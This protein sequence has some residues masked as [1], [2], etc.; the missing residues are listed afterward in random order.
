MNREAALK[1]VRRIVEIPSPSGEE[2][3]LASHLVAEMER[4]GLRSHVDGAGNAVGESGRGDRPLILLLGHM[5]TVPGPIPV[6]E[7]RGILY[8]RGAVDAK[9]PLA[10][11]IC[12]ASAL[13]DVP[14]RVVVVGAVEEET[15]RARGARHILDHYD[16]QAVIIGEPSGWSGVVLGYKG[17]VGLSL[18][19]ARPPSHS[20]SPGEKAVEA[21]VAFWNHLTEYLAARDEGRSLFHRPV[22]TLCELHGSLD[23][24]RIEITCRI[25]PAFDLEEL[26][27]F[28]DTERGDDPLVVE[29]ATPAVVMDRSVS[30]ARAIVGA[31]RRHGGKPVMKVKAGTSD[32]NVVAQ[33]WSCPMVA[34]GP[35]DSSLDHTPDE[36]LD[37]EEYLRAI[38]V[39]REAL[40]T[41]AG[42]LAVPEEPPSG[43]PAPPEPALTP[44]DEEMVAS[45]L[46][47]LGYVE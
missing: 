31:I 17:R 27:R 20:S 23:Q 39:L 33:R 38:D 19:V 5:D 16:P 13:R 37:L 9:G 30:P 6:R 14:A 43:P 2:A 7:E 11:F 45:R 18:E 46:R 24:A 1:L 10:T 41:L 12:A 21:A 35:G 26:L 3:E 28:L 47:S 4:L 44:E 32:M 15:A 22:A 36:R 8:G 25:P 34:Y 40:R 42:E 29:E